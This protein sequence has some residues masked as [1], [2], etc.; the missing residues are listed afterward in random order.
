MSSSM[1]DF[2]WEA[3]S[4]SEWLSLLIET[5]NSFNPTDVE[6]QKRFICDIH[7]KTK[8]LGP[9]AEELVHYFRYVKLSFHFLIF[10][11]FI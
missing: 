4:L 6:C 7:Q 11:H 8:H 2:D 9:V 10:L 3:L 5:Y 1:L